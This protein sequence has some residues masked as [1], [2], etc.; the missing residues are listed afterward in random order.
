ME[1]ALETELVM[2]M[3]SFFSMSAIVWNNSEEHRQW[4]F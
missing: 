1:M 4:D 2:M 3:Y